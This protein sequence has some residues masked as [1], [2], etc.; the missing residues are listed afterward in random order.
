ML[1]HWAYRMSIPP[2]EVCLETSRIAENNFFSSMKEWKDRLH[3][4]LH[5]VVGTMIPQIQYFRRKMR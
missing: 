1:C 2:F 3:D 5:N 4:S